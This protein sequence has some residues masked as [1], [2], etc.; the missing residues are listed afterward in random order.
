MQDRERVAAGP[1]E[2]VVDRLAGAWISTRSESFVF[3]DP[4]TVAAATL[5]R[6]TAGM[7]AGMAWEDGERERWWSRAAALEHGL[8]RPDWDAVAARAER[9][10]DLSP[11]QL[12]WLIAKGPEAPAK[13]VLGWPLQLMWRR[14]RADLGRVAVARFELDAL[15]FALKEAAEQPDLLGSVVLPFRAPEVAELVAGWLGH[16]GSA[17]LWARLWFR[18]HAG[19]AARALAPVAGW[20]PGRAGRQAEAALLDVAGEPAPAP[21]RTAVPAASTL[22]RIRLAGGGTMPRRDVARLVEALTRA[23]LADPPEPPPGDPAPAHGGPPLAVASAAAVQ[24]LVHPPDPDTEKLLAECE[25][26]S[27]AGFGRWLLSQWLADGMPPAQAWVVPAQAHVGDDATMDVL[28]PLVRTW[29]AGGRW[30]RSRH[31]VAVLA[32]VGTD[33]ALRHVLAME[34]RISGGP[35]KDRVGDYLA[36]AAARRGLSVPQ[37]ADRLADPHGLDTGVTLH[38]G[39]RAFRVAVDEHLTPFAVD[40][41]GRRLARPPRPGVRDTEPGAH[42]QFLRLKRHLRVT[43]AAHTARLERDMF[44]HRLR[45]A[46]HVTAVLLP[47]PVLGPIARRLLWAQYGPGHRLIRALRI[48]EDGS[49]ADLHDA[50]ATVAGDAPLGIAH[51]AEL[52]GD[53]AR[54]ARIFTDYEILQPFPQVHRPAVALTG[55]QRT[56]TSLA[57]FGP[58]PT[59]EV[60]ALMHRDGWR[61]N[62]YD[63]EQDTHTQLARDLGGGLT[64]LVELDPG[65]ARS[66][67]IVSHQQRITELWADHAWSEHWQPTRQ[68]P[69]GRCDPAALSEALVEV[70][71]LRG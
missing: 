33:V 60:I 63:L 37:L 71:G 2:G 10:A 34:G 12:S 68:I 27:L 18:R 32:T 48:A 47:H 6:M 54:W 53:R 56:A 22:P 66:A 28:A 7:A 31:G 41:G 64:L 46:R 45:P 9:V 65:L 52:R 62:A 17:R 24:P 5:L 61:G 44:A 4:L 3:S 11:P 69:M 70:Y 50:T 42:Q 38:Y 8:E 21:A 23:R 19:F 57:G 1:G 67:H 13:A 26:G 49:F 15:G 29:P 40:A 59:R 36:Q 58:V 51:P 55:A 20:R 14:Q 35:T 16:L 30:E 43:A 25:P 39:P